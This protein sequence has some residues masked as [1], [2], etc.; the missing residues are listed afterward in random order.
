MSD[1]NS[2]SAT[3]SRGYSTLE[4]AKPQ[5]HAQ[6]NLNHD[7]FIDQIPAEADASGGLDFINDIWMN[8]YLE[9]Q[10]LVMAGMAPGQPPISDF[11][12]D[13]AAETTNPQMMMA[14]L[15]LP[16]DFTGQRYLSSPSDDYTRTPV[17][18]MSAGEP[19]ENI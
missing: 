5:V 15:R 18:R 2:D 7:H 14:N 9:T 19:S 11:V 16:Y 10:D 4:R 13:A 1:W 3:S 17:Q 12:F 8:Q 6:E